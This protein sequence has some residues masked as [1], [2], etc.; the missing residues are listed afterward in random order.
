MHRIERLL[1]RAGNRWNERSR[2][3]R[4]A[5]CAA[6]LSSNLLRLLMHPMSR[7]RRLGT[8]RSAVRWEL[9]RHRQAG[10]LRV[11]LPFGADMVCP[12]WHGGSR[13]VICHGLEDFEEQSLLLD[14]LRPGDVAIDVGA[15]HGI[16]T[17]TMAAAG[18]Q[19][20]AFEPV[21][22]TRS[23]LRRNIDVNA[24]GARVVVNA[25]A[26]SDH[27]GS[28]MIT[29]AFSCGNRLTGSAAVDES[30]IEVEVST[31]D[32]WAATRRP[33]EVTVLKVDAE[34]HDEAVLAG[35]RQ[36]LATH[37]P[38]LLVEYWAGGHLMRRLLGE[39]GYG[40][41]RYDVA[42]RALTAAPIGV[43]GD[44]NFIACT[45]ARLPFVRARLTGSTRP[46][47]RPPLA[48]WAAL[49]PVPAG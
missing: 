11:S 17:V 10:G 18:A 34:G 39:L 9:L 25:E 27:I 5:C 20:H 44:G 26:L 32:A 42:T 2:A 41:Y 33:L 47:P 36:L 23:V 24:F 48:R 29:T 22:D 1:R 43:A 19:V 38:V 7:G 4:Y 31:L 49:E 21:P 30:S 15:H 45:P 40:V 37:E 14:L 8:L 6:W 28:A 3:L 12:T 46:Q 13:T 35:A 16:Y